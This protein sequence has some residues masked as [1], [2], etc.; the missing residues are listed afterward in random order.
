M[1]F[2]MPWL[3]KFSLVLC[4]C[5]CWA[6]LPLHAADGI[7]IKSAE[8]RQVDDD[9]LLY[10]QFSVTLTPMLEDALNRGVSLY[11]NTNFE[12]SEPRWYWFPE[13]LA[14][15][16]RVTRLSYNTLLRQ[17]FVSGVNVRARSVDR[18][19]DALALLGKIDGWPVIARDRLSKSVDYR[20]TLSMQLDTS[21]LPKPLQ[22][23]ALATGRWD[24]EST[25]LVWMMTP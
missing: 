16:T 14:H 8:L 17:Y 21:Q 24:L 23:N 3:K 5:W 10:A 22:I 6:A 9:Y 4:L 12:F 11:F 25:P 19:D 18:L 15:I 1:G 2:F 13:S 20:A 7:Q